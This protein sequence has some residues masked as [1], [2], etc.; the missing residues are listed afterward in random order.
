M[1]RTLGIILA[2]LVLLIGCARGTRAPQR[3][4]ATTTAPATRPAG[5]PRAMLT[6][7]QIEPAPRFYPPS[8]SPLA[9]ESE[10]PLDALELY[11]RA[12]DARARNQPFTAINLLEQAVKLDPASFELHFALGS[13]YQRVNNADKAIESYE[14]AAAI[15]PDDLVLQAEL[16]RAYMQKGDAPRGILH[17][18]LAR[19]TEEYRADPAH[20]AA[21]DYRLGLA[22]QQGGYDR[23]ALDV[24]DGLLKRLRSPTDDMRRSPEIALLMNRPEFLLEQVGALYEKHGQYDDALSAWQLIAQRA[25]EDFA[26]RSR[27]VNTLLALG[28]TDEALKGATDLVAQFRASPESLALLR[29]AYKRAGRQQALV[30]ELRRLRQQRPQDRVVLFALAD[31]LDAVGRASEAEQLL[32][33]AAEQRGGDAEI[34]ARLVDLYVNRRQ[35]E[36]A[37]RTLV[38]TSARRPNTTSDL[39]PLWN[40]LASPGRKDSLRIDD[41]RRLR[42]ESGA[43]PARLYFLSRVARAWNRESVAQSSL[44]RAVA[45]RPVF[46]PAFRE[47][48]DSTWSEA[49][50]D[51]QQ[52]RQQAGAL[53]AAARDAGAEPLALELEGAALLAQQKADDAARVLADAARLA[54]PMPPELLLSQASAELAQN[55]AQRFEQ[56]AWR[57]ISDRPRF[58]PA[59]PALFRHYM[60]RGNTAAARNLLT[61]WLRNVPDGVEPRLIEVTIQ[62]RLAG[63]RDQAERS[64]LAIFAQHSD[65]LDV[66]ANLRALYAEW[67]QLPKFIDLL[68]QRRASEPYNYA[69]VAQLVDVYDSQKRNGEAT[70][71]LD[72][73]RAALA[74]DADRL[75]FVAHLYQRID[76]QQQGEDVL[77]QVLR[78]DPS[79]APAGNDLGYTW[80]DA[81]RNLDRAESMIRR[82][83][84]AEPDNPMFLDSLGWVLYKQGRFDEAR[85][86]LERAASDER[87]ADP[88][89]LDHLGDALYRLNQSDD[90]MRRWR[91]SL[92]RIAATP[93]GARE[94]HNALRLQLDRKLR[95]AEQRQP[96]SV[97]PVAGE[98]RA[99]R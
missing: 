46:A 19:M 65:R 56:L 10:A 94:Q 69:I 59:Y 63:Q 96:V 98:S 11:A 44:E 32:A 21:V 9:S 37:A 16:G 45:A 51:E 53:V 22:L 8:T 38:E 35:L 68:E 80:A 72:A 14:R 25:P 67:N 33:D 84:E 79:F 29:D 36:A 61:T 43:E 20:A 31:A 1:R 3:A 70:R 52:K 28:R 71:V 13:A 74:G 6:L 49:A 54:D 17:L 87:G 75:Y 88:V 83:V 86:H 91:A 97:A 50:F 62:A 57:L 18:R 40:R 92:A 60:E 73:A 7:E 30:D 55:H 85:R 2:A 58:E 34:L 81:G 12:R 66:L 47:M 5:D 89:I 26:A 48:L 15:E 93:E 76:Q 41:L 4:V 64:L 82:A 42:V 39:L 90:A 78:I 27:V 99:Q 77:E 23:A 95:Q 24:Y